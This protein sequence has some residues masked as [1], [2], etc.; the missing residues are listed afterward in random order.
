M[1]DSPITTI[2]QIKGFLQLDRGFQFGIAAKR[3]KYRWIEEALRKFG[4]HRLK[5]RNEK[6]IV[7]RYI[8]KA[9]HIS[10]AQLTILVRRHK[11]CG[12][13]APHYGHLGKHKFK[14]KFGPQ[15]I[16][17]LI[18]TDYAHGHVSGKA[19]QT[20]L[21]REHG[22][23]GR[24]AYAVIATISQSHIYNI[25][26]GN[27][28]YNSSK[29]K[30]IAR[31]KAMQRD[32]GIRA[33]P[34]PNGIPGF[35][36][37]DTVHSGDEG[38]EKGAYHLNIVDEVTQ[39]EMLA[40]VGNISEYALAPIVETLISLYPFVIHEFHSDNGSEFINHVVAA[41]IAKLYARFT[42]SR[43]RHSNDNALVE[44]KNGSIIRKHYGHWHI[45]SHWAPFIDEFNRTYMNI[46]LNYHR[47]CAFATDEIMPD[48]RVK[49]KYATWM[50]P[51]DRLKLLK[52]AEKCLKPGITFA[53]LD[54]IAMEKSDNEF[55][56][57][58]K[59]A[60][61]ALFE[62]LRKNF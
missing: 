10:P 44:S 21:R 9:A 19:T 2:E 11:T 41:L 56:E 5:R 7:R 15:D 36:R 43:A 61:I 50:T 47:P 58:M 39:W 16:A 31:T 3:E 6:S 42:K 20:I 52:D 26:G 24:T 1:H 27:R 13:L 46:Y 38:G 45:P 28:Q 23:F 57:E 40:I 35:L 25:R 51:Y 8:E 14:V 55:A 48:G 29:A 49:K 22:V 12:K 30:W 54:T 33:K 17:L 62:K 59:K 34:R 18:D 53:I 32:I 4:Y 37:V 60:K